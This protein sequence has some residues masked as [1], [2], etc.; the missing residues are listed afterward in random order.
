MRI[1]EFEHDPIAPIRQADQRAFP[2][3]DR[4]LVLAHEAVALGVDVDLPG[5]AHLGHGERAADDLAR[6]IVVGEHRAEVA[7]VELRPLE[8]TANRTAEV[9]A[10]A[11]RLHRRAHGI[12]RRA[13]EFGHH[14][15]V[16]AVAAGREHDIAAEILGRPVGALGA[17]AEDRA[18]AWILDQTRHLG[19]QL[20]RDIAGRDRS[21][22]RWRYG[23]QHRAPE[24]RAPRVPP[25][26]VGLMR[27]GGQR[28]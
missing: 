13:V 22:E 7:V 17:D 26:R 21:L 11:L 12:E 28:R 5:L 25:H 16:G 4:G 18:R 14:R 1:A 19:A 6:I 3:V 8:E 20:E 24:L 2:L 10:T 23:L 27:A 9:E 15:A